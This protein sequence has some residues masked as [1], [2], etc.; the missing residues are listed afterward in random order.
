MITGTAFVGGLVA[1]FLTYLVSMAVGRGSSNIT[2]LVLA[3]VVISALF[4]AC[5]SI[6]KYVADPTA[7][8]R[9]LRFS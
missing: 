5:I 9:A 2:I 8:C 1:V 7:S 4:E 6:T 3:G